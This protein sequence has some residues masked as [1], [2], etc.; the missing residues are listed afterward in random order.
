MANRERTGVRSLAF[1]RWHRETFPDDN[2][3]IDVDLM[4]CCGRCGAPLYLLE[5]VRGSGEKST[6]YL[7]R[8]RAALRVPVPAFLVRYWTDDPADPDRVTRVVALSRP[9]VEGESPLDADGF[10]DRLAW[11]R[12]GHLSTVCANAG[13]EL[14]G[15]P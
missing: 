3:A 13:V 7:T 10:R 1:S 8:L 14:A 12:A 15:R 2:A 5:T 9:R 6:W 4:G 11:L